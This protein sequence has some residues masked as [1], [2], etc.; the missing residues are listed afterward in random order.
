MFRPYAMDLRI[1]VEIIIVRR[2]D[3]PVNLRRYNSVFYPH[4]PDLANAPAL[5]L[6]CLEINCGKSMTHIYQ[7]CGGSMIH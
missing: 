7:C 6:G 5:S 4:Q 1:P 3:Q 2:V